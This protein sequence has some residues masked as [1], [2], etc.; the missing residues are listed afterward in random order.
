MLGG[1]EDWL[2]SEEADDADL[3]QL[4]DKRRQVSVIRTAC[5]YYYACTRLA[6][7]L[8]RISSP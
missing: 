2:Y 4:K 6:L 8:K 7:T 5:R 1:L 3:A